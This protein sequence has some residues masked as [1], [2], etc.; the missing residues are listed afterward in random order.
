MPYK[1]RAK[2][3]AYQKRQYAKNKERYKAN[4]MRSQYY[5]RYGLSPETLEILRQT[6]TSCPICGKEFEWG[7]PKFSKP[8]IDHD[9]ATGKVRGLLCGRC[10]VGLGSFDDDPDRVLM[11]AMYLLK[12]RK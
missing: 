6:Q 3:L 2:Y 12:H 9:H 7:G 4:S 8:H 10:N 1:D 11:A 5:K